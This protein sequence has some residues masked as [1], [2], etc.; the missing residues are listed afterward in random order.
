V[1]VLGA[2]H[3]LDQ[4]VLPRLGRGLRRCYGALR[5]LRPLTVT[6]VVGVVVVGA[7]FAW[8]M[9][10]PAA[11]GA[12]GGSAVRVGVRDGDSVEQYVAAGTA[13]LARLTDQSPTEPLYALVSF[14]A[15]LSPQ[16]VGALAPTPGA[17]LATIAAYARVPVPRRQTELV[18]LPATQVPDDLVAAMGNV[19]DRKAQDV[20]DY[21]SRAKEAAGTPAEV[22][23]ESNADLAGREADAY[24]HA[25][26]CVFALVVRATPTTLT[27]LSRRDGVRVVDAAPEAVELARTVFVAPLPEQVGVVAPPAD[28]GLTVTVTPTP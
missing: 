3:R 20:V 8:R 5:R 21:R 28:D 9:G 25:C 14:S 7:T 23:Y 16:R 13:E 18:R 6:A 4:R 17:D 1:G 19:A 10:E 11:D 24:R 27:T 22:L 2:L 15:Y 12:G 26:A